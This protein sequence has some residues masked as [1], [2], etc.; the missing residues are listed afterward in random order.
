MNKI[1]LN[2]L[3]FVI[4]V[5]IDSKDR[6]F[7]VNYIIDYLYNNFNSKII[8][9]E[10]SKVPL[11]EKYKNEKFEYHFLYSEDDIFH[12]TKTLNYLY[13]KSKTKFICAEDTDILVNPN[14]IKK[15]YDLL[16]ENKYNC[17]SI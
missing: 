6:L 2:D 4:P 14:S 3:T 15:A 11:F 13:N 17:L 7:N 9:C 12:K 16:K 10:N 1:Q 8:V 5:Y